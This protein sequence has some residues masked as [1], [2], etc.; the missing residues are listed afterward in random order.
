[1]FPARPT[2]FPRAGRGQPGDAEKAL[3]HYQRSLEL[4]EALLRDNPRSG[5]AARAVMVSCYKLGLFEYKLGNGDPAQTFMKR[6]YTLLDC[7]V[8]EDRPIDP[9]M[10]TVYELLKQLF[11]EPK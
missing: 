3:A 1:M 4:R 10:R 7:F 8:R 2:G 9:Q 11:T 5:Q 6:C